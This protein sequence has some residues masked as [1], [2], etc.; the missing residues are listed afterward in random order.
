MVL[1]DCWVCVG[2][3]GTAPFERSVT[4]EKNE[5]FHRK[6]APASKTGAAPAQP[7]RSITAPTHSAMEGRDLALLIAGL[8]GV[9]QRGLAEVQ[10]RR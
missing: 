10:P 7:A 4:R 2:L 1:R 6:N 8:A 3:S 5:N 9:Y